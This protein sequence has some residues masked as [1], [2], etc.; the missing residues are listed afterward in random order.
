[1]ILHVQ[2]MHNLSVWTAVNKNLT[3]EELAAA[4][5][6]AKKDLHM[7]RCLDDRI[8]NITFTRLLWSRCSSHLYFL[9]G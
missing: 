6:N 4:A 1:M 7:V 8:P 9:H 3:Y 5:D 2:V